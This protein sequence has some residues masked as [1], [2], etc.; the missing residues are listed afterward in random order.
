[1]K[2]S[3]TELLKSLI[4]QAM[5]QLPEGVAGIPGLSEHSFQQC[6][7][8]QDWLMIF[9]E[10]LAQIPRILIV[11]DA[12]EQ[13]ASAVKEISTA[14]K[15]LLK[16]NSTTIVKLLVITYEDNSA[17]IVPVRNTANNM[18]NIALGQGRRPG[19]GRKSGP[20]QPRT[21]VLGNPTNLAPFL[22][23]LLKS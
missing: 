2:V 11:L 1:M 4:Q 8:S 20:N 13:L 19:M 6:K 17:S 14:W 10:V 22:Q 7:I 18:F 15:G 23:K 21:R 12:T 3:S 9:Q 16:Q 5:H